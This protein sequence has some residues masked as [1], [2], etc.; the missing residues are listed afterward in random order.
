M[1]EDRFKLAV[2]LTKSL[3]EMKVG[4]GTMLSEEL[5]LGQKISLWEV[6]ASYLTMY[7]FPLLFSNDNGGNTSREKLKYWLRPYRGL[8]ARLRDSVASKSVRS[9]T[10]CEKWPER[11]TTVLFLGFMPNYYRDVLRPVAETLSNREGMQAVVV[12][13]D[14]NLP[15]GNLPGG[16]VQYQSIWDHWTPETDVLSQNMLKHLKILQKSF[17]SSSQLEVL[18]DT[19]EKA[20]V[21]GLNREFIWLFWREFK[22]LIDLMVVAEH[23]LEKHKPALIVSADDADQRCRIYSLLAREMGI[24]A[25]LVQQGLTESDYPEWRFFSQTVVAAMGSGS[26]RDMIAQG[27]PHERITVTGHPGFD[28]LASPQPDLC[29]SVRADLGVRNGEKMILFVSQPYYV[30]TFNTPEIRQEMIRA[31]VQA[32]SLVKN[33]RLVVKPHP[34]DDLRDLK[35][36]IGSAT[37]TMMA[38]QTM[39]IVPL[40]KAC[41]VVVTFFSTVALQAIYAGRPVV[42]V[43]FPGSG[44]LQLYEQSGAT[45][46]ARSQDEIEINIRKLIGKDGMVEFKSRERARRNFLREMAYLPDGQATKRVLDLALNLIQTS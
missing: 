3:G 2:R 5:R 10:A 41:D 15:T 28:I 32:C 40:V 43:A 13:M 42:N 27:V 6:V 9:A 25:L 37:Q 23:I 11:G 17:F 26:Q 46:V 1:D 38:D 30:G 21:F 24:P 44:G 19:G 18:N 39:D 45:W 22:R 31:I 36:L 33:N 29:A 34:G 8:L 12:G 14:R 4:T 20:N 16:E 7:R 35:G